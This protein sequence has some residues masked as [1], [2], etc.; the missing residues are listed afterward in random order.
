MF[1]LRSLN[2]L[3][4]KFPKQN[5]FLSNKT[6]ELQKEIDSQNDTYSSLSH[7][8][9]KI[10]DS[11]KDQLE[12]DNLQLQLNDINKRWSLLRK[13]S[14]EIRQVSSLFTLKRV[15][16]PIT[17]FNFRSRLESNSTQWSALL[18]SLK[19]L[20]LWCQ[21]QQN[22]IVIRKQELQPDINTVSKQINENKVFMCNIEYKKSIIESSLASAKLYYD[23]RVAFIELSAEQDEPTST[24]TDE[25]CTTTTALSG[26]RKKFSS[27]KRKNESKMKELKID[28]GHDPLNNRASTAIDN[29]NSNED[30]YLDDDDDDM[31]FNALNYNMSPSEIA[32]H[33]VSKIDKKVQLLDRLWQDLNRQA[34]AYNNILLNF[35][36]NLQ[37][38]HKSFESIGQ[39]LNEN[40]QQ[41]AVLNSA[42]VSEIES[43]KLAAELERVKNFQLRLSSQQTLIDDMC[44]RFNDIN[45][46]LKDFGSKP[47]AAA[48]S[49]NAKFDDLNLRWSN[50]QSQLQEKYLHMYSLIESSGAS[51][52]LKLADSVQS[53]WQRG[54]STANK[55]P[56][57]IK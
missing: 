7:T 18:S 2:C 39:R 52:F 26:L 55:V 13:K 10:L 16:H 57:Y 24:A 6:K 1:L 42:S 35:H 47:N 25:A 32:K 51:I 50:V 23:D 8:S 5:S 29:N 48:S 9:H 28:E 4:D 33:L 53:P 45:Q 15:F 31:T 41:L 34:V 22:Q 37:H 44:T 3:S 36:S 38:V 49:F 17:P 54:I 20:I 40:E 43:D 30:E 21:S 46:D 14:L 12:K 19:E 56:Y 11:F 27:K